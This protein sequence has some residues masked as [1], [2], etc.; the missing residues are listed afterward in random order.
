MGLRHL[1]PALCALAAPAAALAQD[2]FDCTVRAICEG[3][4][5]CAGTDAPLHLVV[6]RYRARVTDAEGRQ[7]L[8]DRPLSRSARA[9]Q[10]AFAALTPGDTALLLRFDARTGDLTITE[11]LD[12]GGA[13]SGAVTLFA[14]CRPEEG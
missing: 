11:H 1:A 10:R 8:L 2:A 7:I 3:T 5:P 9:P 14:T 12:D 4:S 13:T 6:E